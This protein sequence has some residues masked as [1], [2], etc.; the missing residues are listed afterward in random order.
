MRSSNGTGGTRSAAVEQL[1]SVEFSDTHNTITAAQ[2]VPVIRLKTRGSLHMIL[3][4]FL[5][6]QAFLFIIIWRLTHMPSRAQT[7]VSRI[8][9]ETRLET[10]IA[11]CG[12]YEFAHNA[13]DCRRSKCS[14]YC[15]ALI[16]STSNLISTSLPTITPP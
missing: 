6:I 14:L 4:S 10:Y 15:F 2:D 13:G 8:H 3:S 9:G 16:H 5:S 12:Q 7:V 11:P 1:I